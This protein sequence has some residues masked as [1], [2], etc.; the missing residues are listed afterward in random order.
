MRVVVTRPERSAEK[1]A[2]K[3]RTLG[4]DPVLLPLFYPIHHGDVASAA[5]KTPV[6]AIAVTSAEAIRAVKPLGRA[7]DPFLAQ[8]L[9]AVGEAT[10]AAARQAGF[11]N[12]FTAAGD[13]KSLAAVVTENRALLSADTPLLYLAGTPRASAF[14]AGLASAS[15]AFT[16]AECYEMRE[17]DFQPR[18]W[19]KALLSETADAVL[20]YSAEAARAFFRSATKAPY[21][22][23]LKKT[24]F[25]CM[26]ANVSAHI[27]EVFST[28]AST[29]EAAS[30]A[31]MFAIL[32]QIAGT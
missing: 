19:E 16:V 29:P 30:E 21:V 14:E 17:G 7:V 8:P 20:L 24:R 4:H 15:I 31:A 2:A 13:G 26:S 12:V 5:L 25:I 27:P 3:L 10:A 28:Q 6:S 23:A 11:H 18:I 1:T 32:Q 9:F 22:T